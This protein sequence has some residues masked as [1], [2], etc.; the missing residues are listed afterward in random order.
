MRRGALAAPILA[1][2]LG[3][4]LPDALRPAPPPPPEPASLR[5]ELGGGL[6]TVPLGTPPEEIPVEIVLDGSTSMTA[7][8]AGAATRYDAA[9]QLAVRYLS[10]LPEATPVGLRVLGITSGQG[11]GTAVPIATSGESPS[12]L[13]LGELVPGLPPSRGESSLAGALDDVRRSLPAVAAGARV[14][15]LSDLEPACGGDLCEAARALV[16]AG[17]ELEVVPL[18]GAPAPPCLESLA[19]D[20]PPPALAR[21]PRPPAPTFRV[22]LPPR[23]EA[24][25]ASTLLVRGRTDA[26]PVQMPPG[27]V[28]V[29]VQLEPPVSVGPLDLAPGEQVRVRVLDFPHLDPPVR[30]V[31]VEGGARTDDGVREGEEQGPER[32]GGA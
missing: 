11:C 23:P 27:R 20:G 25:G 5:V 1:A 31:W 22:E 9:R 12:V 7:R 2:A 24:L 10:A 19:S 3:C 13:R 8:L 6:P 30:E 29:S 18:G 28:V 4:A 17:A 32:P 15:V 14:V 21:L 26:A 16:D